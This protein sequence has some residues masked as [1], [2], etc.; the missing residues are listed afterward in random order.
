M[1]TPDMPLFSLLRRF[2]LLALAVLPA[3]AGAE[4]PEPEFGGWQLYIDNDLFVG[5][6]RDRD[7]TGGLAWSANGRA[8]TDYWFSLDDW[9]G[10]V[11][12][13]IGFDRLRTADGT[14]A[15]LTTRHGV[16]LGV[17]LFTP[18]DITRS[19]ALPDDHPYANVLFLTNSRQTV[20]ADG[21]HIDQSAL[22]LGLLGSP[23]G[24]WAQTVIHTAVGGS[25]PQGWNHQ[26]SA[27][28]EP[29][30][31]Y[32]LGRQT[33][34]R[35]TR[36]DGRGFDLSWGVKG[37]IGY[38]TDM[39][40][41]VRFRWGR[42]NSPWWLFA[43]HQSDYICLGITEPRQLV[44]RGGEELFLWGGVSTRLRLYNAILQGQFRDSDVTIPADELNHLI[45]EA[46]LGI[47]AKRADGWVFSFVL[48]GRTNEIRGA[49]QPSPVWGSIVIAHS[50]R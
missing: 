35:S 1:Q 10:R 40:G 3:G 26:I 38:A 13:L 2:L 47:T 29:T 43:P 45:G 6:G 33:L 24:A 39:T 23:L 18:S 20:S 49:D 25:D 41:L 44:T 5:S 17:L 4:L 36:H 46:W 15:P 28:G 11:D 34:L 7:Y 27:G 8:T 19:E 14:E 21:G 12:R 42:F 50:L 48:R 22:T 16:E 30:L 31:R 32:A 37:G 9:L